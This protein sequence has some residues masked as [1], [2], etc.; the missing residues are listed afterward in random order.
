MSG[1]HFD[2][3]Q[4]KISYIADRIERDLKKMGTLKN[5]EDLWSRKEFYD[6]YPEEK[7]YPTYPPEVVEKMKEGVKILK[8]AAIYA[9][10]ID[11]FLSGDDGDESFLRRLQEDI[12]KINDK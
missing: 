9:H 10:R 2:Y 6:E 12:E 11:Y 4:H 5:K 3:D 1:G 8:L 7:Y